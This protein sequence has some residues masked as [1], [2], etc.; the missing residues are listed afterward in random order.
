MQ[1]AVQQLKAEMQGMVAQAVAA[2]MGEPATALPT[3]ATAIPRQRAVDAG[4]HARQAPAPSVLSAGSSEEDECASVRSGVSDLSRVWLG[5]DSSSS[6]ASEAGCTDAADAEGGEGAL[7][8]ASPG[9]GT[10]SETGSTATRFGTAGWR[11]GLESQVRSALRRCGATAAA[12]SAR[13]ALSATSTAWLEVSSLA[14]DA[15]DDDDD[16]VRGTSPAR[17][18][19]D[20][21][22]GMRRSPRRASEGDVSDAGSDSGTVAL[23]AAGA[24][25]SASVGT[26][27]SALSTAAEV[28]PAM[29][30][31]H[32]AAVQRAVQA[33]QARQYREGAL[34]ASEPVTA[35]AA[36]EEQAD[37][38][39]KTPERD[40]PAASA[41]SATPSPVRALDHGS[42]S[43]EDSAVASLA[44]RVSRLWALSGAADRQQGTQADPS[45]QLSG[46][47][48]TPLAAP[49]RE[50]PMSS[51]TV[52]TPVSELTPSG[53]PRAGSP[54]SD[55]RQPSAAFLAARSLAAALQAEV[56]GGVTQAAALLPTAAQHTALMERANRLLAAARG[57]GGRG[58]APPP[59]PPRPA[60]TRTATA[61]I[62]APPP[63][64]SP[65][66][67]PSAPPP[68]T[69]LAGPVDHNP[70]PILH[71]VQVWPDR[72]WVRDEPVALPVSHAPP[73]QDAV[74][75]DEDALSLVSWLNERGPPGPHGPPAPEQGP[76]E[77]PP[78]HWHVQAPRQV[79]AWEAP[80]PVPL[81][82]QPP[83]P[84]LEAG[85]EVVLS[86]PSRRLHEQGAKARRVAR[87]NG[88]RRVA[89][90]GP[91]RSG[92][93]PPSSVAGGSWTSLAHRPVSEVST[94]ELLA[95][96]KASASRLA[97]A[98]PRAPKPRAARSHAPH[99][100]WKY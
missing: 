16:G 67:R 92:P 31:R 35:P 20:A 96:S 79:A 29:L 11:G 43:D 54:Q 66:P 44:E 15:P 23:D 97:G 90:R 62:V 58:V 76:R 69:K 64:S 18:L 45:A 38:P 39:P 3:S 59:T 73:A 51:G 87:R 72:G 24:W 28:A 34:K 99:R 6:G 74:P 95:M 57:E 14:G 88:P 78:S 36:R 53:T 32:H 46:P 93:A 47:D 17:S 94:E 19:L 83:P 48:H 98:R 91:G 27:R 42:D 4:R 12:A 37:S 82:R 7:Q 84:F 68:D 33:V 5:S 22:R 9:Q 2:A 8:P 86:A 61:D 26:H 25:D 13:E 40:A 100:H 85:P 1:A 21:A 50:T 77:R 89:R 70:F 41:G 49:P 60:S 65:P 71:Q 56:E 80:A 52:I 55:A 75:E 10:G 63:P 81:A 30:A